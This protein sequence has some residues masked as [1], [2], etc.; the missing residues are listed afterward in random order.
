MRIIKIVLVIAG[1]AVMLFAQ[2]PTFFKGESLKAN[3]IPID[4]TWYGS[5]Y[6][7]DWNGD[8]KKDLLTGQFSY[9]YVRFYPNTGTNN[10]PSFTDSSFVQANGSNI[11]VYAS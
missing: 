4:V 6:A 11:S 7:Y 9:G 5:P 3:N 1:W 8:G 10:N 2:T